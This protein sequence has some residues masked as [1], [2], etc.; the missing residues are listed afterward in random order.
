MSPTDVHEILRNERRR[1]A[2]RC[3]LEADGP[4]TVRALS[5]E[6]AEMETGESPPPCEARKSVYVTLHQN[7]LAKLEDAGIVRCD[8]NEVE[9]GEGIEDVKD[10]VIENEDD[11]SRLAEICAGLSLLGILSVG[12]AAF[13]VPAVL[14]TVANLLAFLFFA[15]ILTVC[16]YAVSH[17]EDRRPRRA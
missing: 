11:G 9:V 1:R 5:E 12:V 17:R 4:V 3:L 8:S 13:G 14:G 16:L 15:V 10:Y 2:I 7:H 6:I